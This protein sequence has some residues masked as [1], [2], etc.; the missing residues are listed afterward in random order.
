MALCSTGR[1]FPIQLGAGALPSA[2]KARGSLGCC[3][4]GGKL[5]P[6]PRPSLR[7]GGVPGWGPRVGTKLRA[8]PRAGC[9]LRAASLPGGTA[10]STGPY[11]N[12]IGIW[13]YLSREI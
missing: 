4:P 13:F 3:T 6:E 5:P 7:Q 11:E 1:S 12:V 10:R 2:R 8:H 9:R